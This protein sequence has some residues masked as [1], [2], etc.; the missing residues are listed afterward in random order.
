[1]HIYVLIH[2]KTK[3][4]IPLGSWDNKTQAK[5]VYKRHISPQSPALIKQNS[6][7]H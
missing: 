7:K 2:D 1:M 6:D 5:E 3:G 4:Q